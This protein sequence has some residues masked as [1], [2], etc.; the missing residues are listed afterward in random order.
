MSRVSRVGEYRI[1]SEINASTTCSIC[2]ARKDNVR[3]L[4]CCKIIERV[5]GSDRFAASEIA[6]IQKLSHKNIV[7]YHDFLEDDSAFYLFMEYCPGETLDRFV[8]EQGHLEPSV[9]MHLFT[10]LIS[11]LSY[12]H[13][14]NIAHRDIKMQNIIVGPS[15]EIK[16][17]DFGF[18]R[19]GANELSSTF[20][21]SPAYL[22]PECVRK[23]A[24]V[25]L[26]SDIWSAG[27]VLYV[28]LTGVFPWSTTSIPQ[29]LA[30]IAQGKV[31]I[32][33]E[34][35]LFWADLL[36]EMLQVDPEQRPTAE[37]IRA[38]LFTRAQEKAMD[39]E[40]AAIEPHHKRC[41]V[42]RII[43]PL[44]PAK[45]VRNGSTPNNLVLLRRN[46]LVRR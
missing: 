40:L 18:S 23:I 27:I 28:M 6:A 13:A 10:Q 14:N 41:Q 33:N 4:F 8:A 19:D 36:T 46:I 2:L 43:T 31:V 45:L 12:M 21:G 3:S 39:K 17:V 24:Y 44:L 20:C 7:K 25:P 26:R 16:V 35:P 34:V 37:E 5:P 30:E 22:A 38:T 9:A 29:M 32:P 1:L 42:A 15:L 11:A